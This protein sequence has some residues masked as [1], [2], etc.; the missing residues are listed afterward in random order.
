MNI[1]RPKAAHAVGYFSGQLNKDNFKT[2]IIQA[3]SAAAKEV[4]GDATRVFRLPFWPTA[5]CTAYFWR[6][7]LYSSVIKLYWWYGVT[8]IINLR[9]DKNSPRGVS[10]QTRC[11]LDVGATSIRVVTGFS[12]AYPGLPATRSC[13]HRL[14]ASKLQFSDNT[15][16]GIASFPW[17]VPEF[18]SASDRNEGGERNQVHQISGAEVRRNLT[19]ASKVIHNQKT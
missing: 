11:R 5:M 1:M 12:C 14:C 2:L 10:E 3:Q 7:F 19:S 8:L 9:V 17:Q 6:K 18:R 15:G 13:H 16:R 4:K